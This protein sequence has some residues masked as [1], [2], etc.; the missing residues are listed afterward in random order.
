MIMRIYHYIWQF[1]IT[2]KKSL[3]IFIIIGTLS[4][5]INFSVFT[6][7]WKFIGVHYQAA[8]SI[9]FMTAV[10]FHFLSNRRFTFESHGSDFFRHLKKYSLV[11][12]INY[13]ITML[14]VRFTVEILHLS[15]YLGIV[16]SI[17]ATLVVGFL[18]G[19]FWIYQKV[20]SQT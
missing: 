20:A 16:F 19:K 9:A 3:L 4:A 11:T 6:V 18:M 15:P 10:V 14:I 7:L 8:V 12:L 1:L 5:I 13:I 17:A 2:N